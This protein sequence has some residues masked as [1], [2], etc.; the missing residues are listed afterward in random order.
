MSFDLRIMGF[1]PQDDIVG[2]L[3]KIKRQE[4][5]MLELSCPYKCGGECNNPIR[6]SSSV[7][8]ICD[9]VYTDCGVYKKLMEEQNE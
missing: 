5:L 6:F 2:F 1:E 7:D 8:L 4:G 3:K 9:N